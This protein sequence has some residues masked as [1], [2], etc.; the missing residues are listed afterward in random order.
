MTKRIVST[1]IVPIPTTK[2]VI[3]L[4]V[5]LRLKIFFPR[6]YPHTKARNIREMNPKPK[7]RVKR[8]AYF[9]LASSSSSGSKYFRSLVIS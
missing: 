6:K 4:P 5:S 9:S 2:L 8:K 7:A 3:R 1:M